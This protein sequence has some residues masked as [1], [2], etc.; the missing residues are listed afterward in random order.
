MRKAVYRLV[1]GW[2]QSAWK[3]KSVRGPRMNAKDRRANGEADVEDE[4]AED[5]PRPAPLAAQNNADARETYRIQDT[6]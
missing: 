5:V 1:G 4:S 2:L 3:G 6:R